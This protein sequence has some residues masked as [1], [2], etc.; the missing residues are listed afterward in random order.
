MGTVEETNLDIE[1]LKRKLETIT[2]SE[3]RARIEKQI[4]LLEDAVVIYRITRLP[5]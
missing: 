1:F 5:V 3:S 2:D 4:A